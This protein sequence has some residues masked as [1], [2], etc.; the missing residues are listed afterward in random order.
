MFGS[1][2]CVCVCF[3]MWRFNFFEQKS[4]VAFVERLFTKLKR[5][6]WGFLCPH[7]VLRTGGT[8]WPLLPQGLPLPPSGPCCF[9]QQLLGIYFQLIRNAGSCARRKCN[10]TLEQCWGKPSFNVFCEVRTET[11]NSRKTPGMRFPYQYIGV[12]LWFKIR[13]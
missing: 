9:E 3:L 10:I 1:V 4:K 5:M 2:F 7:K 8:V 11:V 13:T 6:L 12:E